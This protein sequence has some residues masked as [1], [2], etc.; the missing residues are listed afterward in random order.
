MIPIATGVRVWLAA[1]HT[2]MPSASAL[3]AWGLASFASFANIAHL[4]FRLSRRVG[5]RET[6]G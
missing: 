3:V 1:G 2:D 4:L 6:V 5:E